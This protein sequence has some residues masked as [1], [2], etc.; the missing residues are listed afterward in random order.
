MAT[1]SIGDVE[2]M[3]LPHGFFRSHKSHLVNLNFILKV[4]KTEG[5][6]I[7]MNDNSE[8]PLARGKKEEL[9]NLIAGL[10]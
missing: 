3:L 9:M 4:I 6:F 10:G 1:K 5:G 7:V 2:T 8:V